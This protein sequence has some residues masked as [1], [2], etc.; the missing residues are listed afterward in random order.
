[1]GQA[2]FPL[3]EEL[4]LGGGS[5]SKEAQEWLVRLGTWMPFKQAAQ[6]LVASTGIQVSQGTARGQTE[7]AGAAYEAVLTAEAEEIKRTLPQAHQGAAQPLLSADGAF[8]PLVH[9]EWAEVKTLA[10]FEVQRSRKGEPC[11]YELPSF[12]RLAEVGTFEELAL[13]ETHRRGLEQAQAACAVLDGAE[14]RHR[15]VDYHRP[16]AVRLLD[17]AQAAE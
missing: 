1:V 14:W 11:T 9:G 5:L 17:C 6:M 2:F 4:G 7:A 3:D 15:L 13:V 16:D 8:V 10:L 12:S